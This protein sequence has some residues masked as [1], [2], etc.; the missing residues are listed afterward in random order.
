MAEQQYDLFFGGD[1]VDGFYL[2]LVKAEIQTLFNASDVYV[3]SLF[4]G[5]EPLVKK[6]VDKATA[7][8]FQTAFKKAGG[9]LIV[10]PH[11]PFVAAKPRPVAPPKPAIMPQPIAAT[12]PATS[13]FLISANQPGTP[14]GSAEPGFNGNRSSENAPD[15]VEQRQ[16]PLQA[17][18]A[19]PGW[20]LS[21]P[22]A[23][24]GV[25][26]T[27]KPADIDTSALTMATLGADLL[28]PDPFESPAAI[29]NTVNTVNTD[30]LTLAPVGSRIETL[31]E[32]AAPVLVDISHLRVEQL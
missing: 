27:F 11:D 26:T 2:D 12:E 3:N 29:V 19:V 1:L 28:V 8:K 9:K 18:E 15:L 10:R 20:I 4:S 23:D 7:I 25:A 16:P 22:G 5:Q 32:K 21:V 17:P 24:L 13:A 31:N 6:Q 30:N 14:A